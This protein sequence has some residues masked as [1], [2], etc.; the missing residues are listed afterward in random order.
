MEKS[1]RN[2]GLLDACASTAKAGAEPQRITDEDLLLEE[3]AGRAALVAGTL[4]GDA[5][6]G[7]GSVSC[8][9]CDEVEQGG[10][11][12]GCEGRCGA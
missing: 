1:L 3:D 9:E 5:A 2:A 8:G 12:G 7:V 4:A 6:L 10:L 11:C